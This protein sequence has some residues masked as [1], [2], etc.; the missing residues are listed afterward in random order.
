[1]AAPAA[2]GSVASASMSIAGRSPR[3][4]RRVK[5]GGKLTTNCTSPRASAAR[6][7]SSVSS[8]LTSAK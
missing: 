1:M 5:S 4:S 6:A 7:A 8:S 3:N 2:A